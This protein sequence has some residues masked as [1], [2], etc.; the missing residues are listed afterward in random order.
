[1]CSTK[2]NTSSPVST[3]E[4]SDWRQEAINGGSLKLVNLETGSNGWASPPGDLFS[5][6]SRNYFTKK[7]KSPSGSWLLHPAGV[8]WLRSSSKLDHV[9]SRADNRVMHAL[10]KQQV[11]GS[12]SAKKSFVVAVNLQVPGI[13]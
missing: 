12:N 2:H 4:N 6:R 7:S 13:N 8:D 11:E 1:M 9:L 3:D 10:R 5:L